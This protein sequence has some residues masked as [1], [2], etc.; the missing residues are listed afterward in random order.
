MPK[1]ISKYLRALNLELDITS[2][3]LAVLEYQVQMPSFNSS[4]ND[5]DHR[6]NQSPHFQEH[7]ASQVALWRL[8]HDLCGP[9]NEGST[10]FTI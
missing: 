3:N 1:A 5:L 7:Y 2:N 9:L 8:Y 6:G 10:P 4:F